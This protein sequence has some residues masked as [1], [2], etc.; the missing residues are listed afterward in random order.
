MQIVLNW[1]INSKHLHVQTSS[2]KATSFEEEN[3]EYKHRDGK[4]EWIR[5][6]LGVEGL[7]DRNK[8]Q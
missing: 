6:E 8:K 7:E 1:N 2:Q 3:E 4:A 5:L